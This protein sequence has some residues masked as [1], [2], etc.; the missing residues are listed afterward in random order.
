[1]GQ[2]VTAHERA[3]APEFLEVLAR[4]L[5]VIEAFR[6]RKRPLTLSDVATAVGIP[7]AT[8]RRALITLTDLGFVAVDGR[9]FTLTPRVLTLASAYLTSAIIPA[10][11]QP[12]VE[13]VSAATEEACSAAVLDG[14]DVVFVARATPPRIVSVGL[15]IGY[16]LPASSTAVGRVLLSGMTNDEIDD[17]LRRADPKRFTGRTVTSKK[18]L[19]AAILAVRADGYSAVDQEVEDGFR[20]IAIPVRRA[21]GRIACA[22]HVGTHVVNTSLSEAVSV[23]VPMLTASAK[24]AAPMLI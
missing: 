20:S 2:P 24:K 23:L 15:E 3:R 17:H 10:V 4:G 7:R 11:M 6:D 13:A 22:L 9:L 5:K 21:D 18:A 8:A 12:I 19:K 16:R 1:M 14:D